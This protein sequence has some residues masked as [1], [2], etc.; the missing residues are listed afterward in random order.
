MSF[1]LPHLLLILLYILLLLIPVFLT[2]SLLRD[3]PSFCTGF[4]VTKP[5]KL[6]FSSSKGQSN[7]E[8]LTKFLPFCR[9]TSQI[10][11]L[12]SALIRQS[13]TKVRE[14]S[15]SS[16]KVDGKRKIIFLDSCKNSKCHRKFN[17]LQSVGQTNQ[18]LMQLSV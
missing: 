15:N 11:F 8:D 10:L 16:F 2:H 4:L 17:R 18:V 13:L 14:E 5:A 7:S 9:I 3:F 12:L 6:D 1:F